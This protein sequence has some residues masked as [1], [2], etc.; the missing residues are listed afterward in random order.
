MTWDFRPIRET[1]F[2]RG[3]FL[4]VDI[5]SDPG[6]PFLKIMYKWGK[7]L[8]STSL[9]LTRPVTVAILDDGFDLTRSTIKDSFKGTP[10]ASFQPSGL[11]NNGPN[12]YMS[13]VAVG[14][15]SHG[16][17]MA[18]CVKQMC[19]QVRI[20][21]IRLNTGDRTGNSASPTFSSFDA[22]EV[23]R[24]LQRCKV[25]LKAVLSDLIPRLLSLSPN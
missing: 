12:P 9:Q 19:P 4:T 15:K 11:W 2:Y 17:I 22:I 14:Y 7:F 13:S 1:W 18:Y 5:T 6:D 20:L 8:G 10:S 24:S 16:T 21:P 3:R 25:R 23:R